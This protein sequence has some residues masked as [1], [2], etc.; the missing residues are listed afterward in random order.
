MITYY[1]RTI[2]DAVLK[3]IPDLRNGVWIHAASPSAQELGKLWEKL[4]LDE[5]TETSFGEVLLVNDGSTTKVGAPVVEGATVKA[6][7]VEQ[8]RGKKVIAF[9]FKRRQGYHKT[10]GSRRHLTKLEITSI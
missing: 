6:T 1:F 8:F 9:K 7:V 3:E 5:G 2:K 4:D 10:K